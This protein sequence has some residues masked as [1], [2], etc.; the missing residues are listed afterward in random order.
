MVS[1]SGFYMSLTGLYV[2][3]HPTVLPLITVGGWV[4]GMG[5]GNGGDAT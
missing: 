1:L 5:L 2:S 4:W 3:I